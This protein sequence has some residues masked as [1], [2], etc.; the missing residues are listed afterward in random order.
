MTPELTDIA[1]AWTGFATGTAKGYAVDIARKLEIS[2]AELVAAGCGTTVTR[3]DADWGDVI[4]RLED[5]GEVMRGGQPVPAAADDDDVV[6]RLRFGVA[7][8]GRPA[9][10]AGEGFLD[11]LET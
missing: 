9:L 3:M 5:L 7:P 2:E 8:G 11:D 1:T 6:M 10:V 4:K